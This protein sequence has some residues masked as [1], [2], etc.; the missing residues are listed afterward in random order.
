VPL[1]YLDAI[2]GVSV[3]AQV[4]NAPLGQPPVSGPDQPPHP[5]GGNSHG[6]FVGGPTPIIRN[7]SPALPYGRPL[8]ETS[9]L[10]PSP[11]GDGTGARCCGVPGG[12]GDLVPPPVH[13]RGP[14][15]RPMISEVKPGM[16]LRRVE[17]VYPDI[18]RKT[19][20][21][22]EV[23]LRAVIG[24]DGTIESLRVVSGH[25]MLAKAA[26]EAV[27]QWRFRPYYLNGSPIEVEAQ[28]TVRFVLG[29]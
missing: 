12:L 28:V 16:I 13:V 6:L 15:Q 5:G 24:K 4:L 10:P 2:P 22:G 21:D 14:A 29:N 27:S 25:P 7:M 11:I 8:P 17:P 3:H 18:A 20:T 19:R 9:E 1:L 26:L 23:V